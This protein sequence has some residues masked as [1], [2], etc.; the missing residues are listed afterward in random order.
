MPSYGQTE[1]IGIKDA[2]ATNV[3]IKAVKYAIFFLSLCLAQG[4]PS[5]ILNIV[6]LLGQKLPVTDAEKEIVIRNHGSY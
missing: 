1:V 4:A 6:V 5:S 2:L 3:L